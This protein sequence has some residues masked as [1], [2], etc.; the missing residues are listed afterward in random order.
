MTN[1]EFRAFLVEIFELPEER[2]V[3]LQGNWWNP[4]DEKRVEN[5]IGFRRGPSKPK[6]KPFFCEDEDDG[7][8]SLSYCEVPARLQ[9][10]G[11]QAEAMAQSIAHWPNRLDVMDALEELGVQPILEG[12]GEYVVSDFFQDGGNTVWAYNVTFRLL[13]ELQAETG[14]AQ[15]VTA[16][17]G[18]ALNG[19]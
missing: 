2:I 18:G 17:L 6:I 1:A 19:E 10:V 8:I 14:Q 16:D 12:F 5:W 9:I 4:Q 13:E 7:C 11:A 3:P 15:I